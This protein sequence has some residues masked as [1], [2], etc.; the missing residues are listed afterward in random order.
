MTSVLEWLSTSAEKTH[1]LGKRLADIVQPGEIM[2]LTGN[3]GSGKTV[4]I[5]GVCAGLEVQDPVTSPTFTIVQEYQGRLPVY[6][7]DFY[8]LQSPAEIEDL[9]LSHY[10]EANGVCLIEWSERGKDLIPGEALHIELARIQGADGPIE[11][12]RMVRII[13]P[14]NRCLQDKLS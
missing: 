1:Q 13:D 2:A 4:L 9:G 12:E 10:F 11:N 5:Q 7:F 14:Q 6:H 8:R 3:L